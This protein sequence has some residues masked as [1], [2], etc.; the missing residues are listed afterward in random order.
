MGRWKAGERI[1]GTWFAFELNMPR[2]D[3]Y[4]HPITRDWKRIAGELICNATAHDK[5]LHRQCGRGFQEQVSLP[6]ED[7]EIDG[8]QGWG[9]PN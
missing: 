3:F 6:P 9:E 8:N 7:Y 1:T 2:R 4:R 5:L